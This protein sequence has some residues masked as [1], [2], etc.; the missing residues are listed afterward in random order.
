ML[1]NIFNKNVAPLFLYAKMFRFKNF[2]IRVMQTLPISMNF[3]SNQILRR[4]LK[5][6]AFNNN[7]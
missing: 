5:P 4:M 6:R 1:T 7:T 3:Q 2:L